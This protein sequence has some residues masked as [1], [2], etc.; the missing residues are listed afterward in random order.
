MVSRRQTG[1]QP[2]QIDQGIPMQ[3]INMEQIVGILGVVI[4]VLI[5]AS[6]F[7]WRMIQSRRLHQEELI[8]RESHNLKL[9][10]ALASN[11]PHLQLA[12]A[13]VL[14]ERLIVTNSTFTLSE[15]RVIIRTLLAMT[16]KV[17]LTGTD[18]R[19]VS[20][21][22]KFVAD[23]IA[24]HHKLP[25]N[26]FDWQN[27]DISGAWWPKVQADGIDFWRSNLQACGLRKASL[28]HAVFIES[29]LDKTVLVSADLTGARFDRASLKGTNLSECIVQSTVFE[30]AQFDESTIFPHGF[31]PCT[32]GLI[33]ID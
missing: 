26:Q 10:E 16:K 13:A 15:H 11:N 31:D 14:I 20:S 5:A 3:S 22:S 2:H 7:I 27:V 4:T 28:R 6:P 17:N 30:G 23:K 8:H 19:G 25:L 24:E 18:H 32:S 33:K 1:D 21:L 29:N 12:A 9:F